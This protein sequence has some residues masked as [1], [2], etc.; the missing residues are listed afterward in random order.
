[1]VQTRPSFEFSEKSEPSI[2][3]LPSWDTWKMFFASV[4]PQNRRIDFSGWRGS[5]TQ[6]LSGGRG[7][8]NHCFAI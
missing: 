3:R 2:L 6:G 7:L 8:W 1:M 5:I 4:D